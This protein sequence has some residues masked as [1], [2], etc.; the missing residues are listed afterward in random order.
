MFHDG[1]QRAKVSSI[2]PNEPN[3][4]RFGA[5]NEGAWKNEPNFQGKLNAP[6]Q[7]GGIAGLGLTG[8]RVGSMRVLDLAGKTANDFGVERWSPTCGNWKIC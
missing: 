1:Q 6:R 3:F 8:R 2:A 5:R 4:R 7:G